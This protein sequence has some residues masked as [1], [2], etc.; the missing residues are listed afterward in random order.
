MSERTD[1]LHRKLETELGPVVRN[2]LADA[3]VVEVDINPGRTDL[4]RPTAGSG[5]DRRDGAAG[6]SEPSSAQSVVT[7]VHCQQS[8]RDTDGPDPEATLPDGS[9]FHATIP[10]I[11]TA[12][13]I[14]IRST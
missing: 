9:R 8:Y 4:G 1:R 6:T 12:P 14:A 3:E 5:H 11:T 7:G 10:P 2:A 13:A